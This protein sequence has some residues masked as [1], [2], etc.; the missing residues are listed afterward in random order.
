MERVNRHNREL[1]IGFL[2]QAVLSAASFL[3]LIVAAQGYAP[4][5]L[6]AFATGIVTIQTLVAIVRSLAAEPLLVMPTDSDVISEQDRSSLWFVVGI[7]LVFVPIGTS[8]L[9]FT[10]SMTMKSVGAALVSLVPVATND[11]IRYILTRRNLIGKVFVRDGA[12]VV[13]QVMVVFACTRASVAPWVTV[14]I[15]GLV[16]G[17]LAAANI[18]ASGEL[19]STKLILTWFHTSKRFASSFAVEALMGAVGTWAWLTSV[20]VFTSLDEV[21]AFRAAATLFGLTTLTLSFLRTNVLSH[22]ARSGT[23][24]TRKIASYSL[25]MSLF[26]AMSI[27]VVVLFVLALP[28]AW[29]QRLLGDTWSVTRPI[30]PAAGLF[31]FVAAL[32]VVPTVFLRA[33]MIAWEATRIRMVIEIAN[34]PILVVCVKEGGLVK[35]YYGLSVSISILVITL[36]MLAVIKSR[37][38]PNRPCPA[39]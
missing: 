4:D 30:V 6:G 2:D 8:L 34:I 14:M 12:M 24:T 31:Y 5:R 13:I 3:V 32:T 16:P 26:I 35:S 1:I 36:L 38:Q 19:P 17:V 28:Q 27:G 9:F 20:V 22:L 10:H 7:A 18:T 21:A 29:G 25:G 33:M 37:G 11:H 15:W 23:V 39:T